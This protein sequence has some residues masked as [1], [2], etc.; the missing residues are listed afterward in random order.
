MIR[1]YKCSEI[2][3]V[4]HAINS[5]TGMVAYMRPFFDELHWRLTISV[6]IKA[7]TTYIGD[8]ER[9]AFWLQHRSINHPRSLKYKGSVPLRKSCLFGPFLY[10]MP[11]L[12]SQ[13][14][15]RGGRRPRPRRVNAQYGRPVAQKIA[16]GLFYR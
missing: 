6:N 8:Y 4:W 12:R 16:I 7:P 14:I 1:I 15:D 3:G 10:N 5:L 13:Y 11:F 9:S 2:P